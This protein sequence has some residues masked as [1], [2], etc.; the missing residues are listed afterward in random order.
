MDLID[1]H[2]HLLDPKHFS[3]AWCASVP[4]LN[5]AFHLADYRAASAGGRGTARIISAVFVE[6]DVPVAQQEAETDF[7]VQLAEQ[8]RGALPLSGI[9][10]AAWPESADFPAQLARLARVPAIRG[11]RRV[12]HPMP[13]ELS[14]T[15]QFAQNLRLLA[16]HGFT[17]DLC[18]RPHLL[19]A[20]TRLVA[21]CPETQFVLDHC[22]VPNIANE[23]IDPWRADL[24]RLAAQPNVTC[25]FS[26]LAGVCDP[27]RPMTPQVRPYFEHCLECFSPARMMW[28]SDWP[29]CNLTFNFAAWRETTADLLG[30]LSESEQQAIGTD[31]ARRIYRLT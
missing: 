20:I 18:V 31:T 25:K 13:E 12:L 14:Q 8:D 4:A 2:V 16:R 22:G 11:L 7:F 10:A 21:R 1:T 6:A 15:P 3:Y 29:V 17:F 19:P 9:V 26:G 5:R 27:R 28:G 24:R 30:E 23:E